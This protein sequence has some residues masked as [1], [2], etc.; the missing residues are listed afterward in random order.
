MVI[1][2]AHRS[3]YQKYGAIFDYFDSLLVGLT[4]TPKDEVDRNTYSL[5]DLE[6]GVPT[7]AYSLDEAIADGY[8]VPPSRRS[9]VPLKFLRAGILYAELTE[10]EKDEWDE[11]EWGEDGD[12]PD[13]VDAEALNRWLFNADTVDKVLEILMIKGHKVAGGDRLGKTIIFAKNQRPRRVHRGALRRRTTPN[14]AGHV[15]PRDHPQDRATP[16]SLIDEFSMQG[17][18]AAH[19]HFGRH[20]RHR[21]RCARGGQ[22]GVLQAG[23]LEDEV[24]ADDRARHPA[25]PRPLRAGRR[26]EQLLSSS[27]SA[28][29]SS[30]SVK[31]CPAPRGHSKSRSQS[32]SS[33]PGSDSCARSMR[34]RW[35]PDCGW[36]PSPAST[37]LSRA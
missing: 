31:T 36:T 30:S 37:R 20:A 12:S 16:R 15:R 2:E 1:D 33:R 4:A 28:A 24:L 35:S 34:F 32:A 29:T 8:L 21:H 17:Q 23:A 11:L 6:D 22:P 25:V 10:D 18:S 3:V 27:T 26:Q 5:F 13:E 9:S 7:D 19:R 14:Y